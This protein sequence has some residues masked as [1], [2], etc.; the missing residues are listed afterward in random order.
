M[1][2]QSTYSLLVNSQETGRSILEGAVYALTVLSA[3]A[4]VLQFALQPVTVPV[5]A[6]SSSPSPALTAHVVPASVPARS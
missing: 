6:A 5:H 2:I 4:S 1:K 3:V